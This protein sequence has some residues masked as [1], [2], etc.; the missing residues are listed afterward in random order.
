MPLRETRGANSLLDMHLL[1]D[2]AR[3]A[4][5]RWIIFRDASLPR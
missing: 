5:R 3:T 2:N 4:A 1:G